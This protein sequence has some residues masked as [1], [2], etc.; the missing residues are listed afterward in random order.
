MPEIN[1]MPFPTLHPREEEARF[2]SYWLV[3]VEI[4]VACFNKVFDFFYEIT[5]LS[6]AHSKECL[7]TM[8]SVISFSK[9]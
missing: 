1:G 3:P 2:K 7:V 4:E 8:L 9:A 6:F 5:S